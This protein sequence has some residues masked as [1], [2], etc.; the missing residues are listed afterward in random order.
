MLTA[1]ATYKGLAEGGKSTHSKAISA[2]R[3]IVQAWKTGVRPDRYSIGIRSPGSSDR[4]AMIA[5][6]IEL[7]S[8][9]LIEKFIREVVLPTYDG[10]ENAALLTAAAALGN[11][12]AAE[13]LAALMEARMANRPNECAQLL[14]ALGATDPPPSFRLVAQ[15]GV[16]GIGGV[17]QQKLPSEFITNLFSALALFSGRTLHDAAVGKITSRLEVFDPVTVVVPG[18]ERLC[19]EQYP[20]APPMDRVIQHLWTSAA[21]F[22]LLRSEAPPQPPPDWD[23]QAKLACTCPDCTDL[24][25]FA[26]HPSEQVHRF[27]INKERRRHL[28]EVFKQYGLDMTHETLRVGSPQTLVCTK[29]RRTFQARMNEYKKEIVAMR[30]LMKLAP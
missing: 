23:L 11:K 3:R 29:D 18:I 20:L 9:A 6:L 21:E 14:L 30:K 4:I 17:K 22:L 16:E 15:T 8:P 2:A 24:Q 1:L 13:I 28:H 7:N 5:A 12:N 10:S 19:A 27:R 25:A 26:R